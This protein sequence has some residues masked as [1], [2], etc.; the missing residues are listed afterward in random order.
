MAGVKRNVAKLG[1]ILICTVLCLAL[2]GVMAP[3]AVLA[4]DLSDA[5]PGSDP[6]AAPE[7]PEHPTRVDTGREVYYYHCMPCHGDQGQG[8][9]AEWREVWPEEHQNCWARG[10]HAG[11]VGDLGFPI[12]HDVPAVSGS[13][14]TLAAYAPPT[15]LFDFLLQNHPPQRPGALSSEECWA[16]T[17]FLFYQN[18]RVPERGTTRSDLSVG[19][20]AVAVLGLLLGARRGFWMIRV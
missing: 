11:K 3:R 1:W 15:T 9:T 4:G 7:M 14:A 17:A 19:I 10:C 2:G 8:L 13:S 16:L 12:P 6:L 20:A 5:G 18:G